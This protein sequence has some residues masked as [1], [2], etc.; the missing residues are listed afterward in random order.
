[1][2]ISVFRIQTCLKRHLSS[3]SCHLFDGTP[4]RPADCLFDSFPER[5]PDSRESIIIGLAKRGHV[6]DALKIFCGMNGF[7][8]KPTKFTL[9]TVLSSCSKALD[10][11]LGSQ[12]HAR[13]IRIGYESNLFLSSALV[14]LY[15]KCEALPEARR[16]FDGM[17]EH[18][19]VSW[20]SII[21][22]FSQNGRGKEALVFFKG[23]LKS[24]IT[25]N[26]FTFASIISA[27]K[28]LESAFELATLL[29][30]LVIKLG[31]EVNS[32]VIS[33][34]IDCY[35]KCGEINRA[36]LLF[37]A[38]TGRDV[39]LYNA[40][41]A[42]FSQN[43]LGE[44]AWKLFTELREHEIVPTHFTFSS[45]LNAC[46]SLA[47]LQQGRLIHS[48][49]IKMGS[50]HN[51]FVV[52]SLVDM[53]SKC[54]IVNE[55]RL[56]FD[57]SIEKNNILWTSMITGYAQNGRGA[58]GLNLFEQLVEAG[59]RPDHVCF[60]GILT[61]CV[62][63]GFL[64]KGIAYFDL[65]KTKYGLIPQPDQYACMIDLYGRKGHLRKAKELMDH[66]PFEPNAVMWSSFLG[67]CRIH[68][69]IELGKEAASH[70]FALESHNMVPYVTLANVY[71]EVG[72]WDEVAEVRKM[73]RCKGLKKRAGCS[74]VEVNKRVH[75]FSVSDGSHP[76]S[77]EIYGALDNLILEMR[78][79]GY[80]P[81]HK[82]VLQDV[83][84]EE[85]S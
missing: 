44:E 38:A 27:C 73:M 10:Q 8:I 41:I 25:P 51:I 69:E 6:A 75:V 33:S 80:V 1:M 46:G 22:G 48:L 61:A 64:D 4:Q 85:G 50:D 59:M 76:Q 43:L 79:K 18:D 82:Y 55:A 47:V 81:K 23:M 36:L 70:L 19:P 72:M 7:G 62:H 84:N 57:Q 24:E 83:D 29:H 77:N 34:L 2:L 52:S 28:E 31:V 11:H 54:G 63:A 67:S 78:E 42:G 71:A 15:A 9:C 49:I 39:I 17:K 5:G 32:F 40:M 35:M 66:M 26:C 12:I 60:T 3:V 65:M 74:W 56:V 45:L 37:D 53:Y 16:V 58:D 13:I 20:T 30:A 21:A 68:G 14:D